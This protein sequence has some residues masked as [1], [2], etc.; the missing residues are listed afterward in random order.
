[1][2]RA[3]TIP[4]ASVLVLWGLTI[5]AAADIPT[6]LAFSGRQRSLDGQRRLPHY[7]PCASAS[8][9]RNLSENNLNNIGNLKIYH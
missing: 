6:F 1:V 2:S 3:T 4:R 9:L 5:M 7:F 8:Q